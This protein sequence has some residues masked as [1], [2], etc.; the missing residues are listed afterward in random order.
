LRARSKK[1]TQALSDSRSAPPTPRPRFLLF[2]KK[3]LDAAAMP[4]PSDPINHVLV[5][6]GEMEEKP[7]VAHRSAD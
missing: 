7:M 1:K 4:S 5:L 6:I 3:K 2:W